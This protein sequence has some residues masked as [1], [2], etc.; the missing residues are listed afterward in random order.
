M[1]TAYEVMC[2]LAVYI[3]L[4]NFK[5]GAITGDE[6]VKDILNI[7]REIDHYSRE[8]RRIRNLPHGT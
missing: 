2:E 7:S 6:L 1:A 3:S 8:E 5:S 4:A